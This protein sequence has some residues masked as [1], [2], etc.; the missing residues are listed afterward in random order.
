MRKIKL[1]VVQVGIRY[2]GSPFPA[3]PDLNSSAIALRLR[4]CPPA[5]VPTPWDPQPTPF[6]QPNMANQLPILLTIPF[7][8]YVERAR[9]ALD[10]AGI[11]HTE[12]RFLPFFHAAG[13]AFCLSV[14]GNGVQGKADKA[15]SPLSTPQLILRSSKDDSDLDLAGKKGKP[16]RPTTFTDS[17]DILK[18]ADSQTQL[19]LFPEPKDAKEAELID[20]LDKLFHDTLGPAARTYAYTSILY[21]AKQYLQVGYYNVN[22]FQTVPW[23]LLS[24]ILVPMLRAGLKTGNRTRAEDKIRSAFT[25]VSSV[26]SENDNQPY[27]LGSKPTYLDLTFAALGSIAMGLGQ[28]EGYTNGRAWVPSVESFPD[29]MQQF[30]KEMRESSAGQHVVKMYKLHRTSWI[31]KL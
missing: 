25:R 30:W 14:W 24:P 20:E 21:N 23:A 29:E 22:L 10:V 31:A 12:Y 15:S 26:L 6:I 8:H 18:Y 9:W 17:L 13:V 2:V 16:S 5:A 28:D 7:S 1:L 19:G 4:P 27:L 11:K 3:D